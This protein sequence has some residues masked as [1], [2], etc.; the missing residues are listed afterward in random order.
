MPLEIAAGHATSAGVRENNEDFVG[1][2]T[3]R[4][5]ELARKGVLVAIADGVSGHSGGREAAEYTVRGL[6]TDY[7]A[8]P[9]TWETTRA[10]DRVL[11]AINQWVIAQAQA[12]REVAGMAT[13]LTA[14]VLRGRRAVVAHVGDTRAY[15]Y[16]AG[17]LER[18][19]VDHSWD[20]PD[21]SHV[22]TRAIGLDPQ[23]RVDYGDIDLQ[24]GDRLLLMT[25]GVWASVRQPRIEAACASLRDPQVLA[26]ALVGEAIGAKSQ[27]NVTIAVVDVVALGA[28]TM[29]DFLSDSIALPVPARLKLGATIDGF[30]VLEVLHQNAAHVVYKVNDEASGR[31]CVLKT[32]TPE[33]GGDADERA[34]LMHEEW[35][36]RRVVSRFFP[37]VVRGAA[38]QRSALYFVQTW[39]AGRTLAQALKSDQHFPVTELLGI[40]IK[41]ARGL[42]AL[43]RRSIVHRD[44]KPENIHL[45]E[46]GEVRILDLGVAQS[47]A[48]TDKPPSRVGTP[49]FLA[50]ELMGGESACAATDL[51]AL[52]VTLYFALTR[53]Y[54]YGE[55]E[56]FQNPRFGA[57]TPP[58]R[59]RPDIPMWFENVLLKLVAVD[60]QQRFETAEELL[61]ALER[62]AAQPLPAQRAMPLAARFDPAYWKAIAMVSVLANVLLLYFLLLSGS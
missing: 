30:R 12:K 39:H 60:P 41:L 33:R 7:Y 44:L 45:G 55:I 22:L 28:D 37:E 59:F 36:A 62:G 8:T 52:G 5:E 15:R 17:E 13:T 26:D 50:P 56:P 9:D 25:D 51:Y 20:R 57:P 35:L 10:L 27:D 11:H 43:H 2:V 31:P 54:P 42:G 49:S 1:M 6:L 32:L 46:D 47:G 61:L 19:T 23:L 34:R 21:L 48:D 4:A 24:P 40:T 29:E 53:H 38:E 3:P 14:V 16:R 18:L 58:T